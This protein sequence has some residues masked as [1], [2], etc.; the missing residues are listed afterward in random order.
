MGATTHYITDIVD[1]GNIIYQKKIPLTKDIDLGLCYYISYTIQAEVFAKA[2][3]ILERHNFKFEGKQNNYSMHPVFCNKEEL[4]VLN[5]KSMSAN[6]C[7]L[8][9]KAYGVK[10]EGCSASIQNKRYLIYDGERIINRYL[11]RK[12][13]NFRSGEIVLKYDTCMLIKCQQGILKVSK[14]KI[15]EAL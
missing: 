8:R 3:K 10:E 5:F 1:G 7:V 15:C 14:Y 4:R 6:E 2:L 11:I 9:I 13:S 12:F